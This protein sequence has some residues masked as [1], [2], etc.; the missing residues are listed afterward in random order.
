MSSVTRLFA[1]PL[2]LNVVCRRI[3]AV[4][5]GPA[6]ARRVERAG[7]VDGPALV[8]IW[9]ELTRCWE[10]F[11]LL[12]TH[13][14]DPQHVQDIERYIGAWQVSS[15]EDVRAFSDLNT[16]SQIF[17][18]E[19]REFFLSVRIISAFVS[20]SSQIT[21]YARASRSSTRAHRSPVPPSRLLHPHPFSLWTSA[22][23][24]PFAHVSDF[25]LP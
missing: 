18:F 17:I 16:P 4:L 1:A 3:N 15:L 13:A 11:E 23:I 25:F 14:S 20:S 5:T 12:R 8:E 10:E 22:T 9:D 7:F 19:C 2:H 24:G 21:S 6:A